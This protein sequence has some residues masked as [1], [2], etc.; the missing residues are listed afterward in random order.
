MGL[1]ELSPEALAA[2]G[3][4]TAQ[5]EE[6]VDEATKENH[7][8]Y[9]ADLYEEG[10]V[11]ANMIKVTQ[12]SAKEL[13]TLIS[14]KFSQLFNDYRGCSFRPAANGLL[15]FVMYFEERNEH[16]GLTKNIER[17]GIGSGT[18][19]VQA[20]VET[21]NQN[22]RGRRT[23]TLNKVTREYLKPFMIAPMTN[24]NGRMAADKIRWD[25]CIEEKEY[26]GQMTVYNMGTRPQTM[27]LLR[28]INLEA[29]I[30]NMWTPSEQ[31]QKDQENAKAHMKKYGN[32]QLV[33]IPRYQHKVSFRG[34]KFTSAWGRVD[35]TP[36]PITIGPDGNMYPAGTMS[37]PLENYWLN[38]Q[39]IDTKE[40]EKV[41]PTVRNAA[42][43][44]FA[45]NIY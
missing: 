27:L 10:T 24:K 4:T 35:F 42:M 25:D 31:K 8:D 11:P 7:D 13:C 6:K 2:I 29:I 12:I 23:M 17:V 40:T 22:K 19:R 37:L 1:N 20:Y 14:S 30:D 15:E 9:Y 38:V 36:T 21:M 16:N 41:V 39:T 32:K 3:G 18:P 34:F 28:N 44:G 45:A 33:V 26:G 43:P 5:Q